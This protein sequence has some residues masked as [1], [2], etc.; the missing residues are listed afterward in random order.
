LLAR[1]CD[2]R[3]ILAP[4]GQLI[5]RAEIEAHYDDGRFPG[6]RLVKGSSSRLPLGL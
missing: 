2:V 6:L 4:T 3:R 1:S 5:E